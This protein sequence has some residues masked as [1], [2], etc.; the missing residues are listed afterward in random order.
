MSIN[1][2]DLKFVL[3]SLMVMRA[4]LDMAIAMLEGPA[5][6]GCQHP[7]EK[8]LD[9]STGGD[10]PPTFLCQVCGQEVEGQV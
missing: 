1:T 9:T 5:P 3:G 8:R 10:Q 2:S 6:D 7:E 4:Q